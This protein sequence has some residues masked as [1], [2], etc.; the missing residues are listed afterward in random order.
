VHPGQA[1]RRLPDGSYAVVPVEP[2]VS[3]DTGSRKDAGADGAGEEQPGGAAMPRDELQ[4][5]LVLI[6]GGYRP[7]SMVHRVEPGTVLDGTGG[8]LRNVDSSGRVLAELGEVPPPSDNKPLMPRHVRTEGGQKPASLGTLGGLAT[9]PA[10]VAGW[11]TYAYWINNTGT[12]IS[13]FS[14]L[15]EV[16]PEPATRNGQLIYLFNGIQNAQF[17]Y[18]PVLQWGKSK[19]GGGDFWSVAT[20][21][22][23]PPTVMAGHSDAVRVNPGDA[24]IGAMT[25]ADQSAAGFSYDGGFFGI[26]GSGFSIQNVPELTM[27]VQTLEAYGVTQC[28][29]YP[30][31]GRTTMYGIDIKQGS[32]RPA[33]TWTA[34]DRLAECGQH[35]VIHS[36]SADAGSV[37]LWYRPAPRIDDVVMWDNGKAYMFHGSGYIRYDVAGDR[38]DA[39]YPLPI[40]GNWPG[41]VDSFASNID[42]V[43]MWDNGKAYVFAG[44]QYVRY[45]VAADSADAGYPLLIAGPWRGFPSAFEASIDAG[46]IWPNGKAYFFK[47]SQYIRYDVGADSTDPGYPRPI[48]GNWPGLPP[49]FTAGIDAIVVWDNGKAYI[50]KGK[51][52][53]RFDIDANRVDAGYPL[54][55]AGPWRDLPPDYV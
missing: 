45:D 35:T 52:Y 51:Q 4:D 7:R 36:N 5:D 55:I 42:A 18:Q 22:V 53:C 50:F 41:L 47:G 37:D 30:V 3:P 31:A 38:M 54:D 27:F 16:P 26:A 12:P 15:W 6:P 44:N 9:P 21:Y 17:I 29:D 20:W 8:I 14:T 10:L 43:V 24:L 25:L 23:G 39:G 19:A 40:D 13:Q 46:V 1:L 48:A 49:D 33:V 2:E 28:S 34:F 11:I 32:G